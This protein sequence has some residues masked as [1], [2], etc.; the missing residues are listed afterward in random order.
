MSLR[1]GIDVGG[2]FTDITVLDEQS[3]EIKE[4]KK[5]PSDPAQPIAVLDKILTDLRTRWDPNALAYLLHGSTH[6]LNAL[7]EEKGSPTGLLVTEGFLDIYELGRQWKGDEVFNIFYPGPKRLIPRRLVAQARERLDF[8]GRVLTPLDFDS[9]DRALKPLLDQGIEALAISFLFSYA[10]PEHERKA[11]AHIR[12]RYPHLF[13]SLSAE[14]N[15]VWRE[16]ERTCTTVLN[17]YIGPKM[18]HYI[19]ALE[20]TV[21]KNFPSAHPL[22][23]KSN[24]GVGSPSSLA[25]FPIQTLMSGPVAGVIG[26]HRLAERKGV[27]NLISLDI[28][29]TSCDMCLIPGEPLFKSEWKIGRHPVRIDSVDIE[30]LGAGGGSLARVRFGRVLQVGPESAGSVPGPACYMK[31]GQ[32]P[33]LTDALVVLG[34]LNPK[35]LLGG[36]MRIDRDLSAKAVD[37]RIARPLGLSL[38]AAAL[39]I[40][41]VLITNVVSSM[42]MI[43]IERGYHPAEFSLLAFGGMGPTFATALAAALGLRE[44]IVPPN[45]GNFSATGM[46][47]SDLLHDLSTTR[48]LPLTGTGLRLACAELFQ[49]DK[50]ARKHVMEQGA[51]DTKIATEWLLDM[52]YRGQAYELPVPISSG[53]DHLDLKEIGQRFEAV[54]E[55]RYGHRA[56]R[57]AIEIVNLKVRAR[58]AV[59]KPLPQRAPAQQGPAPPQGYRKVQF[60]GGQ[61]EVAVFHRDQL[62]FGAELQGPLVVEE[63][64][65]TAVVEPNW[66]L[67]VD[68]ESNLLL[69][70][71]EP[72]LARP[73]V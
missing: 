29:G 39:G 22:L 36:E 55:L 66:T 23:M 71:R 33:T 59:E 26:S 49:L 47:L 61:Q 73:P 34:H 63:G 6:A 27:K 17:A 12:K 65:S 7:L 72:R 14:V 40:L 41:R 18:E 37:G 35:A 24:G 20:K 5:V 60:L 64:T 56:E 4:V 2:T 43:T 58:F 3:G 67:R 45:P 68:E 8:Q 10:N 46:L 38:Q 53:R 42:R 21:R 9:V 32:E 52:R 69:R 28:G 48:L 44:V 15:P 31:G 70:P 25:R 1:V 57:E 19:E 13:L 11:A 62:G 54:H 50:F 30:S 51:S 16:Y